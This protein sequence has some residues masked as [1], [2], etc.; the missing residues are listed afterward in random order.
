MITRSSIV[1]G[2]TIGMQMVYP[3]DPAM[4]VVICEHQEAK[5]EVKDWCLGHTIRAMDFKGGNTTEVW[6]Q[7]RSNEQLRERTRFYP[8]SYV[9]WRTD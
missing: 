2:P 9:G 7:P 3:E 5:N 4:N 6:I 8:S 1:K